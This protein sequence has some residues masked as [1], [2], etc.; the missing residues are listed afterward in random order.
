LDRY[1]GFHSLDE[2]FMKSRKPLSTRNIVLL[3]I[4]AALIICVVIVGVAYL[5]LPLSPTT[6]AL[7]AALSEI[8][9]IVDVRNSAQDQP[10]QV[11]NGFVLQSSQ[12]LQTKEDSKV[13]LDLS[14][15]SIVRIGPSTIFSLASEQTGAQGGL[16]Q[17]ELQAGRVWVILKGGSLNVNTPAGL[18][19][20]RGSYMSVWVEP[21]TNRITVCCLEG[22]CGF[23]DKAG[24]VD[25]T[26]GQKIVSS[27]TNTV[28]PVEKMDQIDVQSWLDNSPE[29]G[30]IVPQITSLM[31]S[32]TA[33]ATTTASETATNTATITTTVTATVTL[34][35]SPSAT[36]TSTFTKTATYAPLFTLTSPPKPTRTR[37][38]KPRYTNT[39]RPT[40]TD[41]QEVPQ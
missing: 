33:S 22:K 34:T 32:S 21:N 36:A 25:M 28:P 6:L 7:R 12:Q 27:N 3:S 41:T 37:T 2:V 39:P 31:A 30:P 24:D 14:S 1:F 38:P 20:V 10:N 8:V 35:P 19:S 16:S 23:Q 40:R 18:A 11:N 29:A 4:T 5:K 17:I 13:R 15:G 26:S 9:G